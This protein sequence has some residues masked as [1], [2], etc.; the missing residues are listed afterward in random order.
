MRSTTPAPAGFPSFG[1]PLVFQNNLEGETYGME[2]SV[3][4]QS[5]AG[6]RLRGGYNLLEEHLRVRAGQVD[7]GNALNETADPEQQLSLRSSIDLLKNG[8]LDVALRWVDTLHN[9]NGPFAGTVPSYFEADVRL[10][11]RLSERFELSLVGQNLLHDRHPE[12]GFPSAARE[13]ISRSVFGRVTC[14]F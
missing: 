7:F 13:E 14:Q 10:G 11:W 12:Y 3:T 5:L 8:Q 4:Y 2:L 9:N 1:F 6:W